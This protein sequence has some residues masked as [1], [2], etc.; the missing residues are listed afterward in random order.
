[1]NSYGIPATTRVS[2]KQRPTPEYG[3]WR[4]M[5]FRCVHPSAEC[6]AD[7]GGRGISVCQRWLDSFDAFVDD[8]GPRPSSKHSLDRIDNES[9]YSP[10]NCRW[11]TMRVQTRNRRSNHWITIEGVTRVITD[12]AEAVGINRETVYTRIRRGWPPEA[13]ILT[14]AGGRR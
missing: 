6:Y 2:G 3:A 9:G 5:I 7:Y 11:A 8:M 1:M 13:A 4:G 14:P 12:W 10:E